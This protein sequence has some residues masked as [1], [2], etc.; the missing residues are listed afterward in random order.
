M[1]GTGLCLVV[2]LLAQTMIDWFGITVE[3]HALPDWLVLFAVPGHVAWLLWI[4]NIVHST[5]I[6]HKVIKVFGYSVLSVIVGGSVAAVGWWLM[7]LNGSA[8]DLPRGLQLYVLV[9]AANTLLGALP[10]V[11]R[12]LLR[13]DTKLQTVDRV[14]K[15]NL[16]EVF[17]DEPVG[18]RY[19]QFITGLPGNQSLQLALHEKHVRLPRLP[20]ELDGL[21]IAHL[22]DVHLTGRIG[23]AYFERVVE[24]LNETEPDLVLLTGDLVEK[25]PC[26]DWIPDVFGRLQSKH[27]SYFI[28]GNHD[29][30]IDERETRRR[31]LD[32]GLIDVGGGWR[33]AKIR[34]V[35]VLF[36]GNERPWIRKAADPKTFPERGPGP[37]LRVLL[38]HSPDQL[39]WARRHDFDLMLAGHVHGGQIQI[40]PLGPML[41]PSRFGVYY[42]CG[43]FHRPPTVMHVSRGLSSKLP[44]R[45]FCPP[46]ATTL[47]L[48]K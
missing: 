25:I 36:A 30:R 42:A 29:I 9:C 31:L 2:G 19:G 40:P 39:P 27:G 24:L 10:W 26:W 17:G 12:R 14:R 3:W 44:L 23:K 7:R 37:N 5:G 4:G 22:T 6:P 43:T 33:Q 32:V 45:Y 16:R 13:R 41:A 46:E 8:D 35:D 38:S 15:F 48:R 47:V 20:V 11:V 21:R 1:S 34:G 18:D 28:F